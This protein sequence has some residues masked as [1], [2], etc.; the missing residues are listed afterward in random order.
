VAET[1][2]RSYGMA[3]SASS[4]PQCG[5]IGL[6]KERVAMMGLL[7]VGSDLARQ[8]VMIA[9]LASVLT[10]VGA[11]QV[12]AQ[13]TSATDLPVD[14]VEQIVRDYLMREPEV[15][16]QALEELQRR[17]AAERDEQRKQMLVSRKDDLVNDPATP[18]AGNPDGDVTLVEF[19][20]YRCGYC[21]RVLS[22]MQALME[23]DDQLRVVFKEL[24]V[25]GEESVRAARAA[26]ASMQQNEDLY[27]DFHLA[28]MSATDLSMNGIR[29]IAGNIGL[30]ADQLEAD[31]ESEDVSK[32][33]DANYELASALGIEGTPA[34]VIGETLVPGAVDKDRL[35]TLIEETRTATN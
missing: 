25:L 5:M 27:L 16:Y 1:K 35:A 10:L 12:K 7:G 21:R 17:Q 20:D 9:G 34:F 24:P 28:L 26:L 22:S 19:F 15:I 23:E 6:L 33:I 4:S 13:D 32:A 30:D 2:G 8:G 29:T 14:Q 18:V 11:D 31:M 3:P